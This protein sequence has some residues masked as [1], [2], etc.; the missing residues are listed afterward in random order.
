[1]VEGHL[2]ERRLRALPGG[3]QLRPARGRRHQRALGLGFHQ[4]DDD[5]PGELRH[6]LDQRSH[7]GRAVE[8]LA[9]VAVAVDGDQHLGLDLGEAVD[10]RARAEVR[11]AARPDRADRGGR[12]EG[13]DR[14]RPVG[15]IRGDAVSRLDSKRAQAGGRGRHLAAQLAPGQLAQL[16]PLGGVAQGDLAID[17]VAEDV[18]GVVQLGALEP[19]GP[20]H[21]AVGEHALVG[22]RGAHLEEVP[23]RRPEVLELVHRPPPELVVGLETQ[24]ALALQPAHVAGHRRALDPLGRG[25]PELLGAVGPRR[26]S[27]PVPRRPTSRSS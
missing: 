14:L 21:R 27:Q 3:E 24:A 10:H 16:A 1:M 6:R 7:R 5:G 4:P 11:R 17:A 2:L 26:P 23:D 18:L 12:E 25:L 22:S 19:A 8:L 13:D 15:Q 20:G 9:A